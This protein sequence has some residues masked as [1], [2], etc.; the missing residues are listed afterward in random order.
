MD[1]FGTNL[2]LIILC[3]IDQILIS[4]SSQ[5]HLISYNGKPTTDPF[6]SHTTKFK[7]QCISICGTNCKCHSF[8]VEKKGPDEY[9]C[10][11]YDR[12]TMR[13][14]LVQ[15]TGVHYNIEL[16]D[17]KD[18]YN[19]GARATGVYQVNW[20]GHG[21]NDEECTM[22]YGVGWWWLDCF[23]ST[24]QTSDREFRSWMGFIQTRF[25]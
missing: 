5:Y 23:P 4:L 13:E 12:A 25:W 2:F 6:R 7:Q 24:L 16:R 19:A 3:I 20:M 8:T 14:D 21:P 17:C 22:Q 15:A 1:F 18:L 10:H 9:E 11:F